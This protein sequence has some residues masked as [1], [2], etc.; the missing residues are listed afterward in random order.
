MGANEFDGLRLT[1]FSK[2]KPTAIRASVSVGIDH[3]AEGRDDQ[4]SA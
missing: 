2:V 1:I 4:Q 3:E